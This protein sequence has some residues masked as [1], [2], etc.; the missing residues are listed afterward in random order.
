MTLVEFYYIGQI[1]GALAIILTLAYLAIQVRH[2]RLM[3]ADVNRHYRAVGISEMLLA[4]ATDPEFA[5]LWMKSTPFQP[6]YEKMGREL[7]IT[8]DEAKQVDFISLYWMWLH[9]GQ[10]ASIKTGA[11]LAELEHLIAELY[12]VPPQSVSWELSPWGRPLLDEGFVD[13]VDGALK[14]KRERDASQTEV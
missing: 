6:I 12:S 4:T 14:K 13:F 11:D 9:W 3:A 5:K 2:T 10:Y 1:L 7:N 8:A